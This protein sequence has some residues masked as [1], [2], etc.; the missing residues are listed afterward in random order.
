[1]PLVPRPIPHTVLEALAIL[2]QLVV[3]RWWL[4]GA[5]G[6]SIVAAPSLLDFA[7]PTMPLL[8]ILAVTAAWNAA[9]A[10]RLRHSAEA[11][12]GE[13]LSQLC[14]DLC[15]FGAVLFFSGGATNPLV[16]LLL[17]P[18]A[19]AALS[20]PPRHVAVV[21]GLTIGLYT[22]LMIHFVPLPLADPA[23]AARLHLSGMW[24]TFVVSVGL[25]TWYVLRTTAAIRQRDAALAAA[26][27]QALRD[28]RVLALGTLAAGAAH[29]LGTPLATMA[30]L[31]DELTADSAL[32]AA[33]E[34]DLQ[35]LREQIARCKEIITDLT[36]Q[37][38]EQRSE[39]AGRR[40]CDTWLRALHAEWRARNGE[41]SGSL[42]ILPADGAPL[43]PPLVVVDPTLAQGLINLLDNARR[44][45]PPVEVRAEWSAQR[46]LIA[47]RDHGP[48]FSADILQRAGREPL[49]SRAQG[50]GIGLWLTRAAVERSGGQ[51]HLGN[52]P[53]G[54]GLAQID[55]PLAK[56]QA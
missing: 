2:R 19:L 24:L 7:L 28:E 22:L 32:N 23:R 1:M 45:G 49:G 54:G 46:L 25:I 17:P 53:D 42:R 43:V 14:F 35:L 26:R 21:A 29:E 55:L 56:I 20:L 12:D 11:S 3:L 10:R 5:T 36:R 34:A 8:A 16:S 48:G 31:A 52:H 44:A 40:P 6:L 37:A 9:S 51:L 39:E 38:G 4:I 30:V 15:A 13:I 41:P 33:S 47:V 27:E 18:V 50:S